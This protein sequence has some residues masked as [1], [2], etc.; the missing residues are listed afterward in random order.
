MKKV[1]RL[2]MLVGAVACVFSFFGCGHKHILDGPGMID[3]LNWKAFTLSRSD[4]YTRHNFTITV[5]S[6]E[7]GFFLTGECRDEEG[8]EYSVKDGAEHSGADIRYLRTLNLGNLPDAFPSSKVEDDGVIFL[9][10]PEV[11]LLV[12]YLDGTVQEKV[13]GEDFL[14]Q[15]YEMFLP[16]FINN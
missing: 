6:R 5:E 15:L 8:N 14:I 1:R 2:A 7:F 16:Y 4:S 12:T 11:T 13:I 9:D 10:E 3:D